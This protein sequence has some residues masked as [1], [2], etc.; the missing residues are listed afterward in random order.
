MKSKN[1]KINKNNNFALLH[2]AAAAMVV[3]GHSYSVLNMVAPEVLG[4]AIHTLALEI[5]FIVSG[6]LVTKSMA[7]TKKIYEYYG[8]RIMRLWPGLLF[9]LL[10]TVIILFFLRTGSVEAY[11][12][13]ALY[14]FRKNALFSPEFYMKGLFPNNPYARVINGSLWSLPVELACYLVLPLFLWKVKGKKK[15]A[16]SVSL[17]IY[18]VFGLGA[19]AYER[20]V[21]TADLIFYGTNWKY[22]IT[23]G[24]YFFSGAFY[25]SIDNKVLKSVWNSIAAVL[26]IA[27][28][29][30]FRDRYLT[31]YNIVLL[32]YLVISLGNFFRAP[33]SGFFN[34]L[35]AAYGIY[36]WGFLFQQIT[37]YVMMRHNIA[38]K[39]VSVFVCSMVLTAAAAALQKVLIEKPVAEILQKI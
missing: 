12:K 21:F 7:R 19:L 35:D 24:V 33:A 22:M 4:T 29:I 1:I 28:V 20:D 34:R 15:A 14:Y 23:L 9:C 18:L 17:L 10:G 25:A 26:V 5:L 30:Y 36:L 38:L 16:L 13:S 27:A 6:F 8:K 2:L 11:G 31:V 37:V 3:Y 39:P 32:P